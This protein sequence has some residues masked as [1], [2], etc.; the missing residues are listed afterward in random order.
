MGR[1][2][3]SNARRIGGGRRL[4]SNKPPGMLF[5]KFAQHRMAIKA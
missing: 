4:R 5:V 3:M 1:D 2:E